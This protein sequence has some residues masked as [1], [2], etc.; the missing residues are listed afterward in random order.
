MSLLSQLSL[1]PAVLLV[2]LGHCA[3]QFAPSHATNLT[4]VA[5]PIDPSITISYRV[6]DGACTTAFDTQEQYTGWVNVPGPF[7]TNL[8]FWF[9]AAREP[10]ALLTIWL[11]GGPGSSSM[12]GFFAESGPCEVVEV[13]ADHLET[14]AREWGWDR[15]S[16]ML[17]IDQPN[18]VGFSYDIPTNG[19]MDLVNDATFIP[20]RPAPEG[21]PEGTFLNGTFS[22][23]N[24]SNTANTTEVAAMAIWHMLQGFLAAFPQY[25]P[26]DNSSLGVNL[27]AESYGGKY[28]PIFAQTWEEQNAKRENGTLGASTLEIHLASLGIMNGCVDDLI[29]GPSYV[30]MAVNNTYGL[31]ALSSVRADLANA[32]FYQP[33]GCR[34]KILQCRNASASLDLGVETAA[35]VD[36]ICADA[37]KTCNDQ[38]LS[39]YGDSGRSLYDIAHRLPDSFPPKYYIDY[40]NS[41]VVQEAIGSVVNYTD[42]SSAVYN[43]FSAT[44]DWEREDMVPKLAA[45]LNSGVRL[46]LVYGDRD[47]ICNWFGGEAISM[48]IASTAGGEYADHFPNAGYA[49]IIVNDSYIGGVVRQ[50]GNLSFSRIYQSGHFVPA[51]QPETAFQ[52]FARIIM[53]TS[54]STGERIDLSAFNTTGPLNATSTLSLPPSPSATCYVRDLAGSCPDDAVQ[55]ILSGEG[56]IVNGV[57]Y[58]ESK[59]WPGATSTK[60]TPTTTHPPPTGTVA[61]MSLTGLFTATAT[62]NSAVP[63]SLPS[64]RG[65]QFFG[66]VALAVGSTL[67]T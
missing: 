8:F 67:I 44:G 7:P 15:A 12:F 46:G 38:L 39:P 19:S 59:D 29:Q 47:F 64:R 11:N 45:L 60:T 21:R 5:S 50:F 2:L 36:D 4:T 52:V 61:S 23:L 24:A 26:P 43:A 63:Q 49:P 66:P 25:N 42:T 65:W 18:Q 56:V 32:T 57:W 6:P 10:T 1:F 3:A 55:S 14:V 53:G 51:Y 13:A 48:S 22:S 33:G 16:N 58:P 30:T 41:R 40:L 9:V 34:E 27:F 62:P 54:V 17:F 20:P 31:E 28:G 35:H 37:T